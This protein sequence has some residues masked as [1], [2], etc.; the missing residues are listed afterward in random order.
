MRFSLF[1]RFLIVVGLF[2]SSLRADPFSTSRRID[3]FRD[4][5]SRN[6]SGLAARSDG[7]L[8]NAASIS[9]L[10][11]T[12][13]A[14]LLWSVTADDTQIY[15]GTGPDGKL[16]SLNAK[17][18]ALDAAVVEAELPDSHVLALAA[19]PG[20]GVLAGTSPKAV[21]ALVR[22]G[23]IV[24]QTRLP[25]GSILDIVVW[26]NTATK[27][28]EALVA[29]GAPGRI[30][31]I[32][33]AQFESAGDIETDDTTP[34]PL[35]DLGISQWA[36]IRDENV[37]TL[38][39]LADGRVIAGSAPKGNIYQFDSTGAAPRVLAENRNTEVTDLLAWDGGFFAAL[40]QTTETR[41]TRVNRPKSANGQAATNNESNSETPPA[42]NPSPVQPPTAPMEKFRGRAQLVWFPDGGF[43]EIVATRSNM[44]FYQLQRYDDL[45]LITG[46]EEGELLGYDPAKRLNLTFA[47]AV[48]AQVNGIL[49]LPG[50]DRAF[51]LGGNNPTGLELMNFAKNEK[52]T[53]RT[54]T[55]DLGVPS[56][57]GALRF[58][59]T[60]AGPDASLSVEIRTSFGSD[61]WEGWTDWMPAIEHDGGWTVPD[62]R[63]R[64]F[65]I[66]LATKS[67]SFEATA[68]TLYTL[69]QNQ[70]PRLQNFRVLAPNFA[71][72]PAPERPERAST[73]LG[74]ILQGGNRSGSQDNLMNSEVVPQPGTQVILWDVSDP[75]NDSLVSTF[76]I[77][78]PNE[79][80]WTDLVIES[81]LSYAQ[82]EISHLPEGVYR[83]RLIVAETSPR[84]PEQ[85]L[86]ETFETDDFVVD[87]AAPEILEVMVVRH[88]ANVIASIRARDQLSLLRGAE[89]NLNSG[90]NY[91]VE[92]PT[93]GI[94]DGREETFSL[95]L[96]PAQLGSA[97]A[98]EIVV[99]DQNGNSAARRLPL[100][101]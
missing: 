59:Q 13:D 85:R 100:P 95:E 80:T 55:I 71:I 3:F 42:D 97:T 19:V 53:A 31:H 23:E 99:L 12:I 58:D 17:S 8:I 27:K 94:L 91:A 78:G 67:P 36:S 29:T 22:D 1:C 61:E 33:L 64:Y 69:P 11:G 4:V 9:R 10:P 34:K 87:R 82:F 45:V 74:Q 21:L 5:T 62:L 79:T 86:S 44:A 92:N 43:P 47:G 51:L 50:N 98:I 30:Y 72:I 66:R 56:E 96:T 75:D 60:I 41:E 46:G 84:H 26:E 65:Q 18:P 6:L 77:Q 57:F 93:D 25:A 7:R 81:P 89:F 39:R 52:R 83:T 20:G 73:T 24:A 40:T 32:D 68:A 101:R 70:R 90:V 28:I 49:P 2:V 15:L 38:L 48:A 37:R 63:G 35:A 16:F 14:D 88:G 76:S 54:D